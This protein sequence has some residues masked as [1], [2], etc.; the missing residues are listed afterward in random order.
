MREEEH[1]DDKTI[2]VF[3]RD[4][5]IGPKVLMFLSVKK[6]LLIPNSTLLIKK[7]LLTLC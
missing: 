1:Q 7:L 2:R 3:V 6:L 4:H 5:H